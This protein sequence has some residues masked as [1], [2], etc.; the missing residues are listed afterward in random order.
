MVL[1]ISQADS[2]NSAWGVKALGILCSHDH[3]ERHVG[4]TSEG[5]RGLKP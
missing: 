4:Q 3:T 5:C 1:K 2:E